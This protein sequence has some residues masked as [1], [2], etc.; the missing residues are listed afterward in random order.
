MLTS[1]SLSFSKQQQQHFIAQYQ[2]NL[3]RG[4][5]AELYIS[6]TPERV[7]EKKIRREGKQNF[8]FCVVVFLRLSFFLSYTILFSYYFF[9]IFSRFDRATEL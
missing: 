6:R 1:F 7:R 8:F 4:C 9:F 3:R 5:R 2:H